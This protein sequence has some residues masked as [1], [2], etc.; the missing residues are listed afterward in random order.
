[1]RFT[2]LHLYCS[3][4]LSMSDMEKLY[5]KKIL[6]IIIIKKDQL[7]L[8]HSRESKRYNIIRFNQVNSVHSTEHSTSVYSH[9]NKTL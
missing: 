6:I 8:L 9:H 5:R 2:F 7:Q 1:M 4:Q 3:A